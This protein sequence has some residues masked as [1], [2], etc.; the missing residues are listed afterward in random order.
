MPFAQ[1][2]VK[3]LRFPGCS[4]RDQYI[5][6]GIQLLIMK[7]DEVCGPHSDCFQLAGR[8]VPGLR[9]DAFV[10]PTA[11]LPGYLHRFESNGS[12]GLGGRSFARAPIGFRSHVRA[13]RVRSGPAGRRR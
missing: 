13:A 4:L 5:A 2:W 3:A 11:H 1:G 6:A 7:A 10:L 9:R 12:R 8:T